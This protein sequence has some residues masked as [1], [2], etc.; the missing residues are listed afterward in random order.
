MAFLNPT[1]EIELEG[2]E[3]NAV[4]PSPGMGWSSVDG[5]ELYHVTLEAGNGA[6][7]RVIWEAWTQN[8]EIRYPFSTRAYRLKPQETYTVSVEALKGLKP[9]V[10]DSKKK[11]AH[12][13]YRAIW[14]DL[15]R[16]TR[17]PFEV[18]E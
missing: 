2:E 15:A 8:T 5:A 16:V 13:A 14:S 4:T 3:V 18:V 12:P 17:A 6:Q 1:G 10:N 9:V 11:Y 7:R